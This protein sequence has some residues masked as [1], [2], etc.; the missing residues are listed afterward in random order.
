[1]RTLSFAEWYRDKVDLRMIWKIKLADWLQTRT[2]SSL[3]N[4]T[5]S[6]LR[7]RVRSGLTIRSIKRYAV[8]VSVELVLER[9]EDGMLQPYRGL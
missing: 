9:L 3:E 1:M 7:Q 5:Q 2:C 4:T 8:E 6:T